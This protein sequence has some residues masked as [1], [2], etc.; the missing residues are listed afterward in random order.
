M[1]REGWRQLIIQSAQNDKSLDLLARLLE[2]QDT[3]I[4]RL[5]DS[6]YGWTG[7]GL[8]ATVEQVIDKEQ[9]CQTKIS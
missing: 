9:P 5:R 2:E 7:L 6:G 3:A 1:T 4:Q 8:L